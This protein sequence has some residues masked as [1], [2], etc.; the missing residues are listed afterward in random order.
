M[1]LLS[2][3]VDEIFWV[4]FRGFLSIRIAWLFPEKRRTSR[5]LPLSR[6][7]PDFFVCLFWHC[8]KGP[9]SKRKEGREGDGENKQANWPWHQLVRGGR[10]AGKRMQEKGCS[11]GGEGERGKGCQNQ[12]T[13]KQK[14]SFSFSSLSLSLSVRLNHDFEICSIQPKA[15]LILRHSRIGRHSKIETC[16]IILQKKN[17]DSTVARLTRVSP[18]VHDRLVRAPGLVAVGRLPAV[19]AVPVRA[20]PRGQGRVRLHHAGRQP[21]EV[22][23]S[24]Q[25]SVDTVS[26]G[27]YPNVYTILVQI[28]L[29]LSEHYSIHVWFWKKKTIPIR[30]CS[31]VKERTEGLI[32]F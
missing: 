14:K 27:G 19:P 8:A 1:L 18:T 5:V 20:D 26:R 22:L 7:R 32:F 23:R 12:R 15:T 24:L 17:L 13:L 25:A 10:E 28:W 9:S 29:K 11:G 16:S 4:F 31:I 21:G 30:A 3:D 6:K 2:I